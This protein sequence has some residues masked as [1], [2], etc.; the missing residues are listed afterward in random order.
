MWETCIRQADDD[1]DDDSKIGMQDYWRQVALPYSNHAEQDYPNLLK[2][3]LKQVETI[4]NEACLILQ[5][6]A[7]P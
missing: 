7:G 5:G 1:Y 6:P 2:L 3:F 4:C